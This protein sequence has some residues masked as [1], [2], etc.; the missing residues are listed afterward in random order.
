MRQERLQ[1]IVQAAIHDVQ[2]HLDLLRSD[3]GGLA[4]VQQSQD[5]SVEESRNEDIFALPNAPLHLGV[6]AGDVQPLAAVPAGVL[7]GQL[8]SGEEAVAGGVLLGGAGGAEEHQGVP[9][10][11]QAHAG[12][13]RLHWL[14]LDCQ[15]DGGGL[16]GE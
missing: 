4:T 13:S 8:V 2:L 3:V 1:E 6:S 11:C 16:A 15:G 7:G 5:T 9:G 14:S 10:G 12:H